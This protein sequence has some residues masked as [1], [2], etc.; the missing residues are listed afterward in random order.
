MTALSD[1]N[2][3]ELGGWQLVELLG[4][5]G[6]GEVWRAER[7]GAG[8][9]RRRAAVKRILERYRNDPEVRARFLSEARI[10]TRLEHPNIVSVI[11]FGDRPEPYLVFEFVAGISAADLLQETVKSKLKIPAVVAA[12]ICAEAATALDYA[13]RKRDD[14]GKPLQIVH[15]DVSPHNLLL[16]VEGALKLG[17]FGV[18]HAIDNQFH[19]AIGVQIGKLVYMSPEQAAG[20]EVDGRADIFSLGIV[21][22]ELLTLRP[23]LPRDNTAEALRRIQEGLIEAPITIEPQIPS[24]LNSIVMTALSVKREQR[25]ATAGAFAQALR[26]FVH[27]VA[28]GFDSGELLKICQRLAPSV[29][30]HINTGSMPAHPAPPSV[31]SPAPSA[32]SAQVAPAVGRQQMP[33]MQMPA[34]AP[35]SP[36]PAPSAPFGAAGAG[37][38]GAMAA[39]VVG[40]YASSPAHVPVSPPANMQPNMQAHG[41]APQ[42]QPAKPAFAPPGAPAMGSATASPSFGPEPSV[43]LP[44]R[45]IPIV[46]WIALALF[47]LALLGVAMSLAVR[48]RRSSASA[49]EQTQTQPPSTGGTNALTQGP[50]T[51]NIPPTNGVP[52][53]PAIE[54]VDTPA[55]PA[56]NGGEPNNPSGPQLPAVSGE[57]AGGVVRSG[58]SVTA[59]GEIQRQL[60]QARDELKA[61]VN[62]PPGARARITLA[63]EYDGVLHRVVLVQATSSNGTLTLIEQ[64]CLKTIAQRVVHPASATS[65]VRA[66]WSINVESAQTTFN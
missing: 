51:N 4:R 38:G 33:A 31:S 13:H 56:L 57:D 6:M 54:P 46:V 32:P 16:S 5:G 1:D 10:N 50:R 53:T 17:D 27:S 37:A 20:I 15:R 23:C 28:P 63:V 66:R 40:G 25:F 59:V 44:V 26:S 62:V 60:S 43:H 8:G 19:T 49:Q 65:M 7:V 12:F 45:G 29:K 30:W 11:D 58:P 2:G 14:D 52:P 24:S 34:V 39:G 35:V 3:I 61:C 42:W 21:L 36:G 9:I 18:A 47:V 22:W 55:D 48:A 41:Q 64:Q